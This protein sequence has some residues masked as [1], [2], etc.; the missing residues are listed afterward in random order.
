MLF[1]VTL[2]VIGCAE[3]MVVEPITYDNTRGLKLTERA[4][5]ISTCGKYPTVDC[6]D[7]ALKDS[8]ICKNPV[9]SIWFKPEWILV[10]FLDDNLEKKGSLSEVYYGGPLTQRNFSQSY[11]HVRLVGEWT[12]LHTGEDSLSDTS[13]ALDTLNRYVDILIDDGIKLCMD[14]ELAFEK[15]A[16]LV[17]NEKYSLD[18]AEYTIKNEQ[19]KVYSDSARLFFTDKKNVEALF[20]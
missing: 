18:V 14:D 16:D 19:R 2:C 20:R 15:I 10:D 3:D 13:R 17:K 4:V 11:W 8:V 12:L 6:K 7:S 9:D 5:Y 1:A